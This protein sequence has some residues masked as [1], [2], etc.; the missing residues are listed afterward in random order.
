MK[1][2]RH[3]LCILNDALLALQGVPQFIFPRD[4]IEALRQKVI[5]YLNGSDAANNEEKK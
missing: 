5:G 4:D 2:D 3:E 1:F